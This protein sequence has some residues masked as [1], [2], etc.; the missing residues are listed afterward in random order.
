V[1]LITILYGDGSAENR[2]AANA[3]DA[4]KWH[5]SFQSD[6]WQIF[7]NRLSQPLDSLQT[8]ESD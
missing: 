2:L 8:D 4:L 7:I 6:A 5:A 3:L 1:Y